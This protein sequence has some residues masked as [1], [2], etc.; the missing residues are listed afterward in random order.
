MIRHGGTL[1][2]AIGGLVLS[3]AVVA[4]ATEDWGG[5]PDSPGRETVFT[6]CAGCHSMMIVT[7][8]GLPRDVWDETLDWMVEEQGMAELDAETR[9]LVLDYLARHYGPDSRR[10]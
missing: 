7:Q 3:A 4:Q 8:Q 6:L 5:L 1:I 2:A 9:T 10:P